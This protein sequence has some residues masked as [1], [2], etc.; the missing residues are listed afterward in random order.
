MGDYWPGFLAETHNDGN[1]LYDVNNFAGIH[2]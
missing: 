2:N 1:R